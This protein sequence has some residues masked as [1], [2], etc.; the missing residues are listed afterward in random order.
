MAQTRLGGRDQPLKGLN[1]IR[2]ATLNVLQAGAVTKSP[3]LKKSDLTFVT[4]IS[5]SQRKS[6]TF[7]SSEAVRISRG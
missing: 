2:E 3:L 6:R 1:L 4:S 7:V 5:A